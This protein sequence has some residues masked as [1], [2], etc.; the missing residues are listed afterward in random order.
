M[1]PSSSWWLGFIVLLI[2]LQRYQPNYCVC[3]Q[4]GSSSTNFRPVWSTNIPL[5]SRLSWLMAENFLDVCDIS[6]LCSLHK[7]L[8]FSHFAW[9]WEKVS[10]FMHKLPSQ[11]LLICARPSGHLVLR[12]ASKSRPRLFRLFNHFMRGA[13]AGSLDPS[14]PFLV[15]SR[16]WGGTLRDNTKNGCEGDYH[17]G[18]LASLFLFLVYFSLSLFILLSLLWI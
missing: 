10:A 3:V 6:T 1:F 7:V 11:F 9:I 17:A 16:L 15:S 13:H 14:Q 18:R 5:D 2:K 8:L 12:L 4:E